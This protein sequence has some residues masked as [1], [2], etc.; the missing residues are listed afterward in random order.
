M[1]E[2]FAPGKI[3]LAGEWC[4]L[5]PGNSCIVIA[6]KKG[7]TAQIEPNETMLITALEIG[8]CGV[9]VVFQNGTLEY[10]QK[11]DIGQREKLRFVYTTLEVVHRYLAEKK[12]SFK[13]F[14]LSI[15]S[16][17]S[18][19][20]LPDGIKTKVGLG[21]SAAT[22]VA[23]IKA[24][25]SFHGQKI[26]NELVFKLASIAHV[27]AQDNAGSCFDIAA[28]AYNSIVLYKRFDPA[29]FEKEKDMPMLQL[30]EQPWPGLE[31][32]LLT[33]PAHLQ[34]LVG[35]VGQS[36]DTKDLIKTVEKFKKKNK[37]AHK[38]I[39][40]KITQIVTDL[41][42]ALQAGEK[43]NVLRLIKENRIQLRHLSEQTGAFLETP[44]LTRLIDTADA[45]GAA[46]KFSGAGGGDCGIA[47]CFDDATKEK[48]VAAWQKSGV[49]VIDVISVA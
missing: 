8:V 14:T 4:V 19:F 30:V 3:M 2:M 45:C 48:V 32:T 10:T 23:V 1:M 35:F 20:T 12:I 15:T 24:V 36:A 27:I 26:D 11:L 16:E 39:C 49:H 25:L 38:K 44:E 42:T 18:T 5:E 43:E 9:E 31:I 37:G 28:S 40:T 29:W 6:L 34:V 33:F 21:S 41:V 13:T 47:V 7:V 46:A 17:I 22:V